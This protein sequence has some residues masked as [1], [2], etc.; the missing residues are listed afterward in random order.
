MTRILL[1]LP[2]VV[3]PTPAGDQTAI[4][5]SKLQ[6][7]VRLGKAGLTLDL[8]VT[9]PAFATGEDAGPEVV[10]AAAPAPEVLAGQVQAET[11]AES[12]EVQAEA[13]H[14]AE[15]GETAPGLVAAESAPTTTDQA[16]SQDGGGGEPDQA[17]RSERPRAARATRTTRRTTR[18]T[19][20]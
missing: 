17:P 18:R 11:P 19:R 14:A 6:A 9:G 16:E 3:S 4:E 8:A 12:P 7:V 1:V 2:F 20:A 5:D 10:A 15:G 13:A